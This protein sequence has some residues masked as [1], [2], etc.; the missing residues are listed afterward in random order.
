MEKTTSLSTNTVNGGGILRTVIK[1][2]ILSFI[3][4]LV[5]VLIFALIV[6]LANVDGTAV[7][8]V[9]QAIKIVSAFLGVLFAVNERNGW[10]LKGALGGALFAFISF[11]TFSLIVGSFNW[12]GLLFDVL[13]C[14]VAGIVAALLAAGK[15]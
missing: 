14:A 10:F 11:L 12:G 8:I 2:A 5:F 15:K 3:L 4:S 13:L 9:N 7:G 6:K 1:S